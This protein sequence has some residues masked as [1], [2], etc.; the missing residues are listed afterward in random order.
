V[1]DIKTTLHSL[2][3]YARYTLDKNTALRFNYWYERYRSDD[4]AYDNATVSSSNN[5]ILTGQTSPDYDA[6]VIGVSV[7]VKNW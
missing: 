5:V 7:V 2:Q 6:H 4:W 3:L 1:P